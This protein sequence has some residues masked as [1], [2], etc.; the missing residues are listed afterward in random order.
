[1][2]KE[3]AAGIT[4][5][6]YHIYPT[7]YASTSTYPGYSNFGATS[8]SGSWGPRNPNW[9]AD[10]PAV[11]TWMARNQ[12]VL[13]QGR[14]DMDVA[15]YL[16]SFEFP[17]LTNVNT[18]GSYFGNKQWDDTGLERAGYTWDY[19]NPTM[20]ASPEAKVRGG[21]LA[22]DGPSYGALIV[23]SSINTPSHPVK[24]AMP[25]A[26]AQRDPRAVPRTG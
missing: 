8:F 11:N 17:N 24:T 3:F 6:V 1:M 19:V 21:Q 10:A 7:D 12:Q 2:N 5:L 14:A 26:V 20:L 9:T 13:T 25:I 16:H 4:K 15:V 18:D 22:P 23:N